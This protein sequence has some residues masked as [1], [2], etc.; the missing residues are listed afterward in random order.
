MSAEDLDGFRQM[1]AAFRKPLVVPTFLLA[2]SAMA[3]FVVWDVAREGG[4]GAGANMRVAG[5][6]V[7]LGL[8]GLLRGVW[9]P[10]VR[11]QSLVLYV[12]MYAWQ[13]AVGTTFG[14]DTLLQFPG[15]LIIMFASVL[16]CE[17]ARD[18]W[19]NL[20][21][22]AASVPLVLPPS[23]SMAQWMYVLGLF[24]CVVMLVWVN[25]AQR[26]RSS[27]VIYLSTSQWK[28]DAETDVMTG[29]ANRRTFKTFMERE[30]WRLTRSPSS[31]TLAII[32]IDHFKQVNDQYGH[33]AGDDVLKEVAARLKACVRDE[34]LLARLGGE[35]FGLVMS[36]MHRESAAALLNRLRDAIESRP[37]AAGGQSI[38]CTVSVGIAG[39]TAAD[40]TWDVLYQ[41]ADKALYEAKARGRNQVVTA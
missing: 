19:V 4:W 29:L 11:I 21:L 37:F 32:D 16:A 2:V 3:A 8:L 15:L 27:A 24:G 1:Q 31:L 25:C 12:V 10:S 38:R 22:A 39:G 40:K 5:A 18:A 36:G 33:D 41:R 30:A 17:R 28:R 13:L 23:A 20:M 9:R 14:P 7:A 26:E 34:D 6:G 35:E